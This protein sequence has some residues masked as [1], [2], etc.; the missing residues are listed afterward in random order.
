MEG[1]YCI[2]A[3]VAMNFDKVTSLKWMCIH[4]CRDVGCQSFI[5]HVLAWIR[6]IM[7]YMPHEFPWKHAGHRRVPLGFSAFEVLWDVGIRVMFQH[8]A[9]VRSETFQSW[10]SCGTVLG[11]L[12]QKASGFCFVEATVMQ[13]AFELPLQHDNT[14]CTQLCM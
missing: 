6:L 3:A 10:E 5:R 4:Q 1:N 11:H 7:R 9:S 14:F 2:L 12:S 13:S 8:F